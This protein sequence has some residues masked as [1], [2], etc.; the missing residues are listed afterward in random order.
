M[1]VWAGLDQVRAD[2]GGAAVTI[3]VFDGVH[4][5]HQA[6]LARTVE[7]AA[8]RELRAVAVTF[9]PHPDQVVRGAAP[10]L[11]ATLARRLELL[12]QT[13]LHATLVVEF[14]RDFAELSPQEFFG[15]VLRDRLHARAV[16]AGENFRFGHRGSGD[17][18]TLDRLGRP[19]GIEVQ[20]VS[21]RGAGAETFSSS[22]IRALLAAGDVAG[23]AA[24]LG[25]SHRLAGLVRRG[26][27]RGRALGLPTA[28]LDP[29]P[30][31]AL[32]ADGVYAAWGESGG[33]RWPAAVSVG[34][35]P[36]FSPVL[37]RI[38]AHLL[39]IDPQTDLYDTELQVDFVDRLRE[40]RKFDSAGALAAAMRADVASVRARMVT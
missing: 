35:N 2:P 13:G 40:M 22:A 24:A 12:A 17:L 25:R 26:D 10:P 28:N 9:D 19:D 37:R 16:L 5:G 38:E 8:E 7:L 1:Q 27:G 39:D 14:T 30:G 6:L 3:G 18:A 21:L 15:Q 33:R 20:A 36:T 34:T 11:L 4:R 31:L 32:P 29:P 23:A